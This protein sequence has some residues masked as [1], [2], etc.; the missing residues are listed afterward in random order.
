MKKYLAPALWILSYLVISYAIGGMT[1]ENM[2]W[3]DTLAKSSLNPPD[4]A[5]PLV[6]T[7]L[8]IMLALAGWL[9]W[10]RRNEEGM[11][12]AF[13]LYWVHMILNWGWSFVFF[14]AQ[15]I[16]IGFWWIVVLDIV[17]L[18]LIAASWNKARVV[19]LLIVPTFLWGSFA[20]YLNYSIWV[21]N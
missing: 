2:G 8:Y 19:A 13:A 5:F 4:I 9:V 21:L 10:T 16:A 18:A 7:T 12:P 17:M 1:R 11:K 6:W 15:Q 3:Y 20:A 14:G